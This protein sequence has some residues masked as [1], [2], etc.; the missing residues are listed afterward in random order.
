MAKHLVYCCV[1]YNKDYFKLLGILLKS[2]IV[3]SRY[4]T[5]DFLIMTQEEFLPYVN[6]LENEL[7]I[8]LKTFCIPCTSIFQAACARLSIFDYPLIEEYSKILYLDTDI[9]IKQDITPV[10][11]LDIDD[12]LYAIQSGTINSPSFGVYFFD[13]NTIDKNTTGINSGTLLFKNSDTMK[14]LF[15]NIREHIKEY[16][17]AG[18]PMLYCMDQ[19]FINYGAIKNNLHNN[20]L[21]NPHVSLYEDNNEVTNYETSSICHFAYPIGNFHHKYY[22]MA[23]FFKKILTEKSTIP[24]ETDLIGG[25]YLWDKGFIIFMND[26]LLLTQWSSNGRYTILQPNRVEAVWNNHYHTLTFSDDFTQFVSIRTHPPDFSATFCSLAP[27]SWCGS[28]ASAK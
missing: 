15:L 16:T 10:L 9:I 22:R 2:M 27:Q 25:K 8:K 17:D 19:P 20:E 28:C 24:A 26:N 6:E 23:N 3:F 1:F 11:E 18:R 4:D 14:T 5:F 13:F 21:L 7:H 12:K